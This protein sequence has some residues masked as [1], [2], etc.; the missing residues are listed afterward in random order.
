MARRR[1]WHLSAQSAEVVWDRLGVSVPPDRPA[2]AGSG[3]YLWM[4][5]Q[6]AGTE[7][8][9][10][11]NRLDRAGRE[12]TVRLEGASDEMTGLVLDALSLH[13]AGQSLP[14]VLSWFCQMVGQTLVLDGVAYCEVAT[15][16]ESGDEHK[17]VKCAR[18]LWLPTERLAR[19][20][21]N[22]VERVPEQVATR[23]ECRTR[24]EIPATK[25]VTFGA[26]QPWRHEL[27]VIRD[28]LPVLEARR[29]GWA[30]EHIRATGSGKQW[31]IEDFTTVIRSYYAEMARVT[32]RIGWDGRGLWR[33]HIADYQWCSRQLRWY[34]FCIELRDAILDT[35]RQAIQI[36]AEKCGERARLVVEN[37][38]CLAAVE[39]GG[40][41][42]A[43][44]KS[45]FS[46]ILRPLR[47]PVLRR[48]DPIAST[49]QA[50]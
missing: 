43:S 13:S 34:Q 49:D 46:E 21:A 26:P 20:G 19:R 40:A 16:W 28:C 8:W 38:P 32:R 36:I 7:I 1:R 41:L 39:H 24:I 5:A 50:N 37:M 29:Y 10:H 15:G 35:I 42:L 2:I 11:F 48:K 9:H 30:K 23:L 17:R 6:D 33:E 22:Y 4:L 14:S 47:D 3:T 12:N 27:N 44:G 45:P 18:L 25:V 31:A